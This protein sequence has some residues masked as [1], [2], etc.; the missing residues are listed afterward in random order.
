L[1]RDRIYVDLKDDERAT[2]DTGEKERI[3]SKN[4]FVKN[5]NGNG[6][7]LENGNEEH[8]HVVSLPS[9]VE[10]DGWV[11]ISK[12]LFFFDMGVLLEAK[13]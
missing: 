10:N 11:E 5:L 8:N 13:I 12:D 4:I 1:I 7:E 9:E 6:Y 2:F 3:V